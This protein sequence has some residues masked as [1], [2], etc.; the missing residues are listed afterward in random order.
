MA[1]P[2]VQ[3]GIVTGYEHTNNREGEQ[4]VTMLQVSLSEDEDIQSVELYQPAG[5]ETVP[6]ID[7]AVLVITIAEGFKVAI[8]I[9]DGLDVTE[10]SEGER[11]AYSQDEDGV[12]RTEILQ[13]ADGDIEIRSINNDEVSQS[14]ITFDNAG[15]ATI[16]D[17]EDW[18]VQFTAMKDAFDEL[19][20]DLNSLITVWNAFASAYVPGSPTATGTPPSADTADS[21]SADMAGAKIESIR[22]P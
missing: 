19:K 9:N 15:E 21:S 17:G 11:L 3:I 20:G 16:N 6:P 10:L 14:S 2:F 1:N 13:K 4:T 12:R 7:S 5:L 22:V 18:A 8:A